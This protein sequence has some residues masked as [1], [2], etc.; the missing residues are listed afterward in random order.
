M[1]EQP[2]HIFA[3]IQEKVKKE[4]EKV[5]SLEAVEVFLNRLNNLEN[6]DLHVW[7]NFGGQE[8]N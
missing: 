3:W 7:C 8:R 2:M 5:V 1:I 4:N 6:A